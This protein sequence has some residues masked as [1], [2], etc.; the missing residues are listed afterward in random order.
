MPAPHPPFCPHHCLLLVPLQK[1]AAGASDEEGEGEGDA[2]TAAPA[3]AVQQ[4]RKRRVSGEE[5]L[6]MDEQQM[7]DIMMTR[8]AKKMYQGLQKT[9][10]AKKAR[11]QHL[12][13]KAAALRQ[14][15]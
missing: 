1:S 2:A 9:R 7:K 3:A 10:A 5:E 6:A 15:G 8:K 14:Q 12:E 11:V 13:Q 4:A